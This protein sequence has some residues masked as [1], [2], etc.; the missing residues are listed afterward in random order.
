MPMRGGAKAWCNTQTL[1]NRKHVGFA[2][3]KGITAPFL[4]R[5]T[6]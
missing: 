3:M 2:N 6:E 5:L 4:Y 1:R